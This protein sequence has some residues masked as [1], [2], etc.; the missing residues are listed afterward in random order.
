MSTSSFRV[1]GRVDGWI[2]EAS[3]VMMWV[4]WILVGAREVREK[5]TDRLRERRA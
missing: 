3:V 1:R 4:R 2:S 5:R